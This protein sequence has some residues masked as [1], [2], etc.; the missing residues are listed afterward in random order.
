MENVSYAGEEMALRLNEMGFAR[1][2]AIMALS[3]SNG[4]LEMAINKLVAGNCAPPPY[5][6]ISNDKVLNSAAEPRP[7]RPSDIFSTITDDK[8]NL[9][10]KYGLEVNSNPPP[11]TKVCLEMELK[12]WETNCPANFFKP[13]GSSSDSFQRCSTCFDEIFED[14]KLSNSS[15]RAVKDGIRVKASHV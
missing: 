3:E 5:S 9:P 11:Y 12:D 6:E 14:E 1:S 13:A 15:N 8:S 10:S 2:E 7:S 4:N